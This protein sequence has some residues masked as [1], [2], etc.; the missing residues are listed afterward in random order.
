M[1]VDVGPG[2]IP[3]GITSTNPAYGL[4]IM[5]KLFLFDID[6]KF[7]GLGAPVLGV[8]KDNRRISLSIKAVKAPAS[9]EAALAAPIRA[10]SGSDRT[11]V[12]LPKAAKK[13]KKPLRGGLS[14]HFEW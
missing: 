14:S 5:L 1:V 8:D 13:R 12:A 3:A 4:F 7:V 9:A 6:P 11:G 2:K 10:G